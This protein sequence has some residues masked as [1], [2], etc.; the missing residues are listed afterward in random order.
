MRPDGEGSK[1]VQRAK[2]G[3]LWLQADTSAYQEAAT[4]LLR[5]HR[6]AAAAAD[7]WADLP[8]HLRNAGQAGR[9]PTVPPPFSGRWSK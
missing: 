6:V 4:L 1:L 5:V 2:C 8:H 9:P 3:L 7:L